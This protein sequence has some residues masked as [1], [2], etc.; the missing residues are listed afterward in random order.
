M[1]IEQLYEFCLS[2]KAA[3]EHFPFDDDTLVFKVGGKMFALSSLKSWEQGDP[4]INLKC[5]PNKIEELRVNYEAINSG[6]H[7]SKNHWNTVSFNQDV[8]D[9]MIRE[10]IL[11]SYDLVFKSL[12]KKIQSEIVEFQN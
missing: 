8:D 9:K 6:Y 12:S 7:M 4:K 5:D 10:L 3:T 1:N 2:R 11:Q